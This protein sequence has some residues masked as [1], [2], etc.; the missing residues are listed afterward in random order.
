MQVNHGH[1]RMPA[2]LLLLLQELTKDPHLYPGKDALPHVRVA[3]RVNSNMSKR[4]KAGDIVSY[5]ICEVG[6]AEGNDDA[7]G[8]L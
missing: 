8:A 4:L 2:V 6:R 3:L 1:A 5:V 7:A